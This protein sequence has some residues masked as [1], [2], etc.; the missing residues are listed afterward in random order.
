VEEPSLSLNFHPTSQ[1]RDPQ[2]AP[3]SIQPN[4]TVVDTGPRTSVERSVMV[5]HGIHSGHFPVVG[6]T[7]AEAR[8]TLR[9][10]LNIDPQAAAVIGGRIVDETTV[11][12]GDTQMLSFVKPSAVKG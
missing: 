1:T 8:Q 9:G 12:R 6:L 3:P 7:I 10:L 5:Q 4:D 2:T 11:I